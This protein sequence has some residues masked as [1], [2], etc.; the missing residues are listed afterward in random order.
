MDIKHV[1]IIHLVDFYHFLTNQNFLWFSIKKRYRQMKM[2]GSERKRE[3]EK[4][5]ERK[6]RYIDIYIDIYRYID[7]YIEREKSN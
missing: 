4:L 3:R 1:Q 7:I 6:I 2:G 5:S